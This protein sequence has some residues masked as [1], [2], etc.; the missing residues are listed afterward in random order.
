MKEKLDAKEIDFTG[1]L[2]QHPAREKI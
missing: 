1:E 2:S